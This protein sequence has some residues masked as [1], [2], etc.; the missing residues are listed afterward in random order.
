MPHILLIAPNIKF[1]EILSSGGGV[2]Y[3][4]GRTDRQTDLKKLMFTV[5]VVFRM[6]LKTGKKMRA[7][8]KENKRN[9]KSV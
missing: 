7:Q 2:F 5:A 1:Q 6:S 9:D 3:V 4:N 8:E